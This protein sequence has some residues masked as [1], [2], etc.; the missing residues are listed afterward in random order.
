MRLY[1]FTAVFVICSIIVTLSPAFAADQKPTS[2][3][4]GVLLDEDFSQYFGGEVSGAGNSQGNA[5]EVSDFQGTSFQWKNPYVSDSG[6]VESQLCDRLTYNFD[7]ALSS[8][9][10]ILSFDLMLDNVPDTE[11]GET[12]RLFMCR[13]GKAS[14][15]YDMGQTFMVGDGYIGYCPGM[16]SWGAYNDSRIKYEKNIINNIHS[17]SGPHNAGQERASCTFGTREPGR[18]LH[19]RARLSARHRV[20]STTSQHPPR[21]LACITQVGFLLP[22]ARRQQESHRLYG[23]YSQRQPQP[24]G[25]ENALLY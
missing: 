15:G 10:Y 5:Q 22:N 23:Q 17:R 8:G 25:H 18:Q 24:R 7:T 1:R 2:E 13:L 3:D 4:A 16:E 14:G 11:A 6:E 21:R 20:L 19:G 9:K 12:G